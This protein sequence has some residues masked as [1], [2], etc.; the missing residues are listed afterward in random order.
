MG[1][2]WGCGG[3]EGD[4][5]GGELWP[6]PEPCAEPLPPPLLLPLPL[7]SEEDEE[8]DEPLSPFSTTV[9]LPSCVAGAG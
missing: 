6:G 9:E 2:G 4:S 8:D 7:P 3:A 5:P 1:A